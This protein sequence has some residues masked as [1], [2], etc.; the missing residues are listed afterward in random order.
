MTASSGPISKCH[1]MSDSYPS[2]V[3]PTWWRHTL[4]NLFVALS[5]KIITSLTF[6]GLSGIAAVMHAQT[7][8]NPNNRKNPSN[9]GYT[10]TTNAGNMDHGNT[11]ARRVTRD[12]LDSKVTAKNLIGMD[13]HDASGRKIGAVADIVIP[14]GMGLSGAFGDK[15]KR[16]GTSTSGSADT[17]TPGTTGT[18]TAARSTGTTASDSTSAN[19]SGT[20]GANRNVPGTGGSYDKANDKMAG[21]GRVYAVISAGG[22]LGMGNDLIQVDLRQL[23]YDSAKDK[24]TLNISESELTRIK[25]STTTTSNDRRGSD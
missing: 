19:T 16:Y 20:T 5:M 9:S 13:V 6:A 3:P 11:M 24:I 1:E 18:T 23:A 10:A 22:F 12:I 7:D 2:T 25:S 14:S 4:I 15:E 21:M 17:Y 8:T